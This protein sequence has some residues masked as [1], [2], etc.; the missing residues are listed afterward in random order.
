MVL[1]QRTNKR[2]EVAESLGMNTLKLMSS[3]DLCVSCVCVY[4]IGC[5]FFWH[6]N[7]SQYRVTNLPSVDIER[8]YASKFGARDAGVVFFCGGGLK[9][10]EMAS[11]KLKS[12]R[13]FVD[14]LVVWNGCVER[15]CSSA[16]NLS[17]YDSKLLTFG[18]ILLI[19]A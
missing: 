17:Q 3:R 2:N 18:K 16:P 1:I 13:D 10:L 14:D 5:F 15:L 8:G 4:G 12:S 7:L 11:L 9:S 19:V 6:I